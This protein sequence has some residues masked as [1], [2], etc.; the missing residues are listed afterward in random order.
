MERLLKPKKKTNPN[1]K[2]WMDG[3]VLNR[4]MKDELDISQTKARMEIMARKRDKKRIKV[5]E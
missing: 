5:T 3:F 2:R 1:C 4:T